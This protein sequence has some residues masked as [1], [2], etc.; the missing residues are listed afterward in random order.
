MSLMEVFGHEW[1][2]ATLI[3]RCPTTGMNVQAWFADEVE[4]SAEEG[5]FVGTPC[6][7]CAR[8][9]MVSPVT[10]KVLGE[11]DE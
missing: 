2:M 1:W 8:I 4:A 7:A 10:G 6:L 9:H 11:R 5:A 3:Y